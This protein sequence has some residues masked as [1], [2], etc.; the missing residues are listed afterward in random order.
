MLMSVNQTLSLL[1]KRQE[2]LLTVCEYKDILY[3][4]L[5]PEPKAEMY[6]R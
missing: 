5:T 4:P 2:S 3:S 1:V 6:F